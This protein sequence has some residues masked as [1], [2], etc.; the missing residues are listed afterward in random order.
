MCSLWETNLLS[1]IS[2]TMTSGALLQAPV[3]VVPHCSEDQVLT[4]Q[5][6]WGNGDQKIW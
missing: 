3:L 5:E 1:I 6:V 4:T 2:W